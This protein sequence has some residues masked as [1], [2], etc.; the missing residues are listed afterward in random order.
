MKVGITAVATPVWTLGEVAGSV[1]SI[2]GVA[3][4]PNDVGSA[5][6]LDDGTIAVEFVKAAT[7]VVISVVG[8]NIAGDSVG[9]LEIKSDPFDVLEADSLLANGGKVTIA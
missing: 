9:M 4:T 5:V 6:I 8:D 7:G 1:E 3:L 2:V